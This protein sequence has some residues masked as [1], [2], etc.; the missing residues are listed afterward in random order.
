MGLLAEMILGINPM[1][2]IQSWWIMIDNI[3]DII[4]KF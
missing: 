3:K 1:K 2:K 4:L